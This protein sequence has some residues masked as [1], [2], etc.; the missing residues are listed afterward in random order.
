MN[1]NT[2]ENALALQ[3]G[4][5]VSG[6]TAIAASRVMSPTSTLD[7]CES[8]VLKTVGCESA[9]K[10]DENELNKNEGHREKELPRGEHGFINN[11]FSGELHPAAVHARLQRVVVDL[12]EPRGGARVVE[13]G[14]GALYAAERR[15]ASAEG[16]RVEG[17]LLGQDWA[18]W[19]PLDPG[20]DWGGSWES[21]SNPA[22]LRVGATNF[23]AGSRTC[24]I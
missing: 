5:D 22:H 10:D 3:R 2:E 6:E 12:V 24:T 1:M 17:V 21:S 7:G 14:D 13:E 15:A 11:P 9:R 4:R 23:R 20:Q 19:A 8:K 18:D 16:E